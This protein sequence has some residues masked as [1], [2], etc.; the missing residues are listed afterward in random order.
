MNW[1]P[2]FRTLTMHGGIRTNTPLDT[3]ILMDMDD[4]WARL[5]GM[6]PLPEGHPI[7][8]TPQAIDYLHTEGAR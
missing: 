8:L 7:G 1:I 4:G 6:S 2:F 3:V 5:H